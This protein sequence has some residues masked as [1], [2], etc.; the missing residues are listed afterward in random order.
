MILDTPK[1]MAIEKLLKYREQEPDLVTPK[2]RLEH[3]A[4]TFSKEF[5]SLSAMQGYAD[6]I[7]DEQWRV[8]S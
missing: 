4:R 6:S 2:M 7:E 5:M 8:I 1:E 3:R